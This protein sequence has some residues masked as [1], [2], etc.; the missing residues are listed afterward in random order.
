MRVLEHREQLFRLR[1]THLMP[2]NPTELRRLARQVGAPDGLTLWNQ[3]RG[4]TRNVLRLQ[5]RVFYSPLLETVS[6]LSGDELRLSPDAA[7]DRLR[8]L[9]FNDPVAALRHIEAL[10]T[11]LTAPPT[12]S[13]S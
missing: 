6:R 9:G 4:V 2:D 11:G 12:F 10:T 8:A 3:W 1:R 5:Q 13:G 7:A